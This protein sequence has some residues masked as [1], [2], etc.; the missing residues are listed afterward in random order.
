M[1]ETSFSRVK[2]NSN[3]LLRKAK[4]IATAATASSKIYGIYKS[5][6]LPGTPTDFK[7]EGNLDRKIEMRIGDSKCSN[8]KQD[9]ENL[10]IR[11]L[12]LDAV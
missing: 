11:I 8:I 1:D 12:N 2:R 9:L 5:K 6:Q 4:T 7:D 3:D 10:T